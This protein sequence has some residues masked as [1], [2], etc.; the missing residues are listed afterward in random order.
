MCRGRPRRPGWRTKGRQTGQRG[1]SPNEPTRPRLS[2]RHLD[3]HR[4]AEERLHLD[5][6]A[7]VLEQGPAPAALLL[8]LLGVLETRIPRWARPAVQVRDPTAAVPTVAFELLDWAE[9]S[10]IRLLA[11]SLRLPRRVA[12]IRHHQRRLG[13][14]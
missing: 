11:A 5:L 10:R 9:Q 3:R 7:P 12:V 2:R 8:A 1:H 13:R 14:A 4:G 6:A